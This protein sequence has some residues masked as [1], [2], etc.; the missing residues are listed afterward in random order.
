MPKSKSSRRYDKEYTHL[1]TRYLALKAQVEVLDSRKYLTP[2][3]QLE[4]STLKRQKLA[5]RDALAQLDN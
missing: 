1:Q 3:E 2:E 5:A 4:I